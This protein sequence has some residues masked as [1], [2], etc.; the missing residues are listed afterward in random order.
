MAHCNAELAVLDL[1]TM[2]W[3]RPEA[4][5]PVPPPR[6]G[7]SV[8]VC[9]AV[10]GHVCGRGAWL[11]R[12]AGAVL[13]GRCVYP[14]HLSCGLAAL[15][16]PLPLPLPAGHAGSILAN[17]WFIVGGGN[18]TSGCADMYALDLSPL[19]SEGPVQVCRQQ[20]L[21]QASWLALQ[22]AVLVALQLCSPLP[23]CWG[24]LQALT[25]RLLAPARLPACLPACSGRW[26]ATPPWSLPSPARV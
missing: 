5:G 17:T 13:T 8:C 24:A 19:G 25:P 20:Q 11:R 18:N 3:S 26:W 7:A 23:S 22:R 15:P 9:G 14:A 16:L 4:E 21:V 6:A 1:A 12:V 2:Q 10:C